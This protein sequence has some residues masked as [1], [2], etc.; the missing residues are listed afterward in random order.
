MIQAYNFST[1]YCSSMNISKTIVLHKR[2]ASTAAMTAYTSTICYHM[3]LHQ[4]MAH[5]TLSITDI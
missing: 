4:G 1:P 2:C 5:I 3:Q